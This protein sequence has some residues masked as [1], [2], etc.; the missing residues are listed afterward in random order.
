MTR[1]MMQDTLID[2]GWVDRGGSVAGEDGRTKVMVITLG[3]GASARRVEITTTK[4]LSDATAVISS[5][6]NNPTLG[7]DVTTN[8]GLTHH[9]ARFCLDRQA[10]E[11]IIRAA[12][13]N[14]GNYL[15]V[16]PSNNSSAHLYAVDQSTYELTELTIPQLDIMTTGRV[17][18]FKFSN[19]DS[20]IVFF[21]EKITNDWQTNENIVAAT[22][23]IAALRKVNGN[24]TQ[25]V[26]FQELYPD[27]GVG[28]VAITD[29]N[30]Y[31]L[32]TF[33]KRATDD[34]FCIVYK[35]NPT[36]QGY[37]VYSE[38]NLSIT[39]NGK[40]ISPVHI[41]LSPDET[42]VFVMY[43]DGG[44]TTVIM[45][46]WN[47]YP[48]ANGIVSVS[49]FDKTGAWADLPHSNGTP[50]NWPAGQPAWFP[51]S[52]GLLYAHSWNISRLDIDGT[53]VTGSKLLPSP[54]ASDDGISIYDFAVLTYEFSR[55][56]VNTTDN[57][58]KFYLTV[59]DYDKATNT[60]TPP[61]NWHLP[62]N[63]VSR[64]WG[65]PCGMVH[66]PNATNVVA[67]ATKTANGFSLYQVNPDKSIERIA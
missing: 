9:T 16:T 25:E 39:I 12:W 3:D 22:P 21:G 11:S 54:T 13:S 62:A 20:M 42:K 38:S 40:I 32:T 56:A 10:Y 8:E 49:P 65:D 46:D 33:L 1:L 19:D 5:L 37:E 7:V 41:S 30:Q 6:R 18:N 36:T 15:L 53:T 14:D 67:Q 4:S 60:V 51:D 34:R 61:P 44:Y 48:F 17:R 58:G 52:S 2:E 57:N 50:A 59:F 31:I 29:D 43:E 55:I 64:Q 35:L 26:S 27:Y 24:Y 63:E 23:A 47:I 28:G 66:N 45:D